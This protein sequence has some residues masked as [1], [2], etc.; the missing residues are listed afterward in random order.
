M[1]EL[2]FGHYISTGHT[3]F[4]T[5]I[6]GAHNFLNNNYLVVERGRAC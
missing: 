4:G 6:L 1:A 3:A 2:K 5:Q